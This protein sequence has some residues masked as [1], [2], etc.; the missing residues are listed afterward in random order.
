M[1]SLS[2]TEYKQLWDDAGWCVIEGVIP[3]DDLADAA[4]RAYPICSRPRTSSPTTST[5]SATPRS[6]PNKARHG[7]SSRS[8]AEP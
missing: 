1:T 7:S 3:P 6:S 8:N 4:A 2:R 5:L